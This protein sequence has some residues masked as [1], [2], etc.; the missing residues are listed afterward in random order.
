MEASLWIDCPLVRIDPEVVHGEPVF[1]G[2]RM[3]VATAIENYYALREIHGHSDEKAVSE[4][5][6]CFPTI[7][8][9]EALRNVLA[10]EASRE[11]QLAP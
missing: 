11:H 1:V 8:G 9:A 2:T 6:R 7:P 10:F 3:P 4:T 5:L